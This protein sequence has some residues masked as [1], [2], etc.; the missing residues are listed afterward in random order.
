MIPTLRM[1]PRVAQGWA[2]W[3]HANR[4]WEVEE[5]WHEQVV[6][7]LQKLGARTAGTV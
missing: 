2:E 4:S 7:C 5:G 6:R 1:T 3:N